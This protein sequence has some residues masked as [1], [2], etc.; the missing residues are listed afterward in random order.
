MSTTTSPVSESQIHIYSTE[1]Y[2]KRVPLMI[3]EH[4]VLSETVSNDHGVA[5]LASSLIGNRPQEHLLAIM[6]DVRNHV[7]AVHTVSIGSQSSCYCSTADILRAALLCGAASIVL[8]HNH[9]SGDPTPSPD[10]ISS[11][12]AVKLGCDAVGIT[13]LDH[14]IVTDDPTKFVSLASKRI[15]GF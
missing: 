9:P 5:A 13:L 11:T 2:M 4:P 15:A 12:V 10:D 1:L 6:T 14:V 7:I 3:A 8:S